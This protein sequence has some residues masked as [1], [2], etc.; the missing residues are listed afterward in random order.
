VPLVVVDIRGNAFL[1]QMV[2]IIVGTLSEVGA[3]TR[4]AAQVA[5]I[6]ASQDR[7]RAGITAPACGLE[8]VAVRYDGVRARGEWP[9][10]HV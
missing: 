8:L 2:R 3:G 10:N 4:P 5:E 6:L 9:A 7:T 1:R